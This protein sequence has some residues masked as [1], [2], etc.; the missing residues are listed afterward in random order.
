M[1]F[2]S[3][4]RVLK[5]PHF[6]EPHNFYTVACN[7]KQSCQIRCYAP[8]YLHTAEQHPCHVRYLWKDYASFFDRECHGREFHITTSGGA[9]M[10]VHDAPPFQEDV[11]ASAP[12]RSGFHNAVQKS[13]YIPCKWLVKILWPNQFCA[14][15]SVS[16]SFQCLDTWTWTS[17]SSQTRYFPCDIDKITR[18]TNLRDFR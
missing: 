14:E 3:A 7:S 15:N 8:Y 6:P 17:F 5:M 18:G 12:S 2:P 13:A 10:F 11:W 9:K 1:K 4:T 16:I